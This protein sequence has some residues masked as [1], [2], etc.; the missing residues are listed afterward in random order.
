VQGRIVRARS[1][2][3]FKAVEIV[4]VISVLYHNVTCL[5]ARIQY[6]V[7]LSAWPLVPY[8]IEA[9]LLDFGTPAYWRM[10]GRVPQ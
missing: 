6:T 1:V 7:Y 2:A 10:S 4:S 9:Y 8:V 5:L 3:E